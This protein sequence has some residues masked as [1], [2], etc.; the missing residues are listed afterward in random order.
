VAHRTCLPESM[1][2]GNE[3]SWRTGPCGW[4]TEP[5]TIAGNLSDLPRLADVEA[6]D[7][8]GVAQNGCSPPVALFALGLY[9]YPL[10][11]LFEGV[12]S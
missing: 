2:L 10:G 6:P 1:F 7:W 11:Q 3:A 5:L 12:E 8:S 4:H 9:I